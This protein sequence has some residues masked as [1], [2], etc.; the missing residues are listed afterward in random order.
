MNSLHIIINPY[1]GKRAMLRQRYYLFRLLRK[2]QEKFQYYV[3][4]YAN[5]A[6]EIARDIVEKGGR[7]LLILGGDG[8]LSESINGI[9]SARISDAERQQV[10]I[11]IMPRGTGNDFGRFWHLNRNHRQSLAHFFSGV[12]H[13]IDIG[14]LTFRRNGEEHHRYFINS[15]GFG[16]DPLTC[17]YAD[18]FKPYI[19][20][21]HVNYLF[22]L[23]RALYKQ[24]PIPMSL[25]L[26]G[27]Q[28]LDN[29]LYTMSIGN[30]PYSGGGIRQNPTAD[31]RDGILNG[32]F[33]EKPTL[34]QILQALPNLFNGRLTDIDFVHSLTGK[35]ISI[36]TDNH[37]MIEADGILMHFTGSCTVS[38]IHHA[39]QFIAPADMMPY[40]EQDTSKANNNG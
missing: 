5:H 6:T 25:S 36:N 37:L 12:P 8:T 9:M 27:K 18:R 15:L 21:H 13:P 11:G 30:G 24:R 16:V 20:S 32:M 33:L 38:C 29:K 17:L 7:K 35:E 19:G 26:D 14:C 10:Q 4:A 2:R 28:L 31:P 23:L 1:S 40:D 3:T 22:G 34:R 39:I